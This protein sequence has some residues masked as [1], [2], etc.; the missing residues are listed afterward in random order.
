MNGG[1]KMDHIQTE[2]AGLS[3]PAKALAETIKA[4]SV[5]VYGSSWF[6][7]AEWRVREALDHRFFV[8]ADGA[9]NLTPEEVVKLKGLL[10]ELDG[11][12]VI[13]DGLGLKRHGRQ[14]SGFLRAVTGQEWGDL[15]GDDNYRLAR[16]D[17]N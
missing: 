17:V 6:C 16:Y 13:L 5:R 4:I 15:I 1:N 3:G 2:I 8:I 10:N 7:D 14:P 12:W 9:G 11:G